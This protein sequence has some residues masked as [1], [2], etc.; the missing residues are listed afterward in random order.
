MNAVDE[1][2]IPTQTTPNA[3]S[4]N[5]S[6]SPS[7]SP[8]TPSGPPAIATSKVTGGV[9]K[10]GVLAHEDEEFLKVQAKQWS[11]DNGRVNE[12]CVKVT[13][14]L[15][16]DKALDLAGPDPSPLVMTLA[17]TAAV[18]WWEYSLRLTRLPVNHIRDPDPAD[19]A[20]QRA[21]K[22]WLA[23]ARTLATVQKMAPS[24]QINVAHGPMQVVNER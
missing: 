12:E 20:C 8:M 9:A 16:R 24:I 4:T 15:I 10:R 7:G 6:P 22:R 3:P 23:A 2:A 21:F 5:G 1:S 13:R 11:I 14:G 18:C 17:V 19:R